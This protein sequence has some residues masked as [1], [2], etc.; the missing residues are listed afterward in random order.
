MLIVL[1]MG[2]S[3]KDGVGI[4]STYISTKIFIAQRDAKKLFVILYFYPD[5]ITINK[6]VHY[7]KKNE[8]GA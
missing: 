6:R 4:Y 3:Y 5:L 8:R 7:E 2:V 1:E